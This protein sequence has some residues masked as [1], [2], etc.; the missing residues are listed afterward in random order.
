MT[1]WGVASLEPRGLIDRIY[2][3]D[4]NILLHTQYMSCGPHGFREE[5]FLVFPIM[6]MGAYDSW[7]MA[8][9]D[10]RGMVGRIY[11]GDDLTWLHT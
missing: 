1:P 8:S 11:V 10:P 6:S 5:D 2:V 4:H 7:G 9:L 3:G